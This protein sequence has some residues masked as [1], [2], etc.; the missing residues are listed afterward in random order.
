MTQDHNTSG[1]KRWTAAELRRLPPG[2]R[3]AILREA[4]SEAEPLYSNDPE[5]TAFDA[6]GE[7]DLH[8]DSSSTETR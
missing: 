1:R 3:D 5:L 8:V 2:E 7:D 4:A 6:F